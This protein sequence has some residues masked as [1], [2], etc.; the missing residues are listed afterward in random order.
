VLWQGFALVLA[1]LVLG[2]VAALSL[3]RLLASL[4]YD[5]APSDPW[6]F[7]AVALGLLAAVAAACLLP[8]RRAVS[9]DPMN[10]LR[11]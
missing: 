10:V 6:T 3:T 9:I 5:V 7:V 2:I 1:G 4:L 11:S 8:A